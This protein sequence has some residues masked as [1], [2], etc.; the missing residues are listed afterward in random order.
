ML[1]DLI[2]PHALYTLAGAQ[3]FERGAAYCSEGAVR[4]LVVDAESIMAIVE[5]TAT[6]GV[7]LAEDDGVLVY[8]CDCL[9][10]ADSYFCKHCVA[11]GLAWLTSRAREADAQPGVDP[12]QRIRAYLA[13]QP[14]ESLLDMLLNLARDDEHLYQNLLLKTQDSKERT[15]A[16]RT[17]IERATS[18]RP[19]REW[20]SAGDYLEDIES[21]VEAL[22][23]LLE[24]ETAGELIDLCEYA[25]HRV[26]SLIEQV[27]EEGEFGD[28]IVELCDLHRAACELAVPDPAELAR[29]LFDLE[30]KLPFDLGQIDVLAYQGLLGEAGLRAYRERAEAAW[31]QSRPGDHRLTNIM[32]NLA[33]LAEDV[34]A[35][36][37]IE[38]RDLTSA[39]RY[40]VIAEILK[41]AGREDE[42]LDWAE[43][44][45][46]AF[47]QQP[48]WRLRDFLVE[49]YLARGRHDEAMAMAWERYAERAQF[50]S[51]QQLHAVA[52]RIGNWPEQR[53]R[54]LAQIEAD[55]QRHALRLQSKR[56]DR[57]L[58]VEIA[59]WEDQLD[60]AWELVHQGV[61]DRRLLL[62]LACKLEPG[63]ADDAITLY[64]R[65]IPSLIEETNNRAY[66][67]AI[68]LI[69]HVGELMRGLARAPD[70]VD[71]FIDL[72][73]R[74]KAKRNFIKLLN[75][76]T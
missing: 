34:D 57:S 18:L 30:M 10:A 37:A 49:A 64:Q 7:E 51:Y 20:T 25:L 32:R 56:P 55:S 47:P 3:A 40:L 17:R 2:T 61:N 26:E 14:V 67:E 6:H 73:T 60:T 72:R 28:L 59:L 52:M 23:D 43:R 35:L 75:E 29:R 21:L 12:W 42:A 68:A 39:W 71:Y 33:R 45:R 62:A 65:V 13:A 48:D 41:E 66:T 69:R 53:E 9:R 63:R 70:F 36:V 46:R 31:A 15:A 1:D 76:V 44:G 24:P 16:L 22:N 54:A 5:G 19:G 50:D 74:Y 58:R 8:E 11:V 4:L 38:A 27:D